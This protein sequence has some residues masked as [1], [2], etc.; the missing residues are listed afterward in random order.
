MN[1]NRIMDMF[2]HIDAGLFWCNNILLMFI[3]IIP[4]PVTLLGEYANNNSSA[5]FYGICLG[6]A[7][8]AFASLRVCGYFN[9]ELLK[10]DVV[11]QVY[12]K[13]TLLAIIS[14]PGLYFFGQL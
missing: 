1:H 8:L 7:S 6:F 10:P 12:R 2:K 5:C 4:F 3:T 9:L 14:G 13:G 11:H